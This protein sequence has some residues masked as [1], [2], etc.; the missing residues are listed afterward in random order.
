MREV[1]S[2]FPTNYTEWRFKEVSQRL[3][4][5]FGV[6]R[7]CYQVKNFWN[8]EGRLISGLDERK[9]P[10][11]ECMATGIQ[12]P[13][14][15]R[16][17]RRLKVGLLCVFCVSCANRC[18]VSCWWRVERWHL[19]VLAVWLEQVEAR[20]IPI[21][22]RYHVRLADIVYSEARENSFGP[23]CQCEVS[24]STLRCTLQSGQQSADRLYAASKAA[25]RCS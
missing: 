3:E 9:K 2:E 8:R 21:P 16:E 23:R 19:A 18:G 6:N 17:L 20:P 5:R 4:K 12:D 7:S 11:P 13:A 1:V 15:R 10:R 14:R 25:R 22:A 24:D